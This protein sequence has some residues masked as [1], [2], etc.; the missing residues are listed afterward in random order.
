ML[1]PRIKRSFLFSTLLSLTLIVILIVGVLPV[2]ATDD[3]VNTPDELGPY[4]V[5]FFRTS[6]Y[7]ESYGTYLAKVK[8]P[9]QYDGRRACKDTSGA[10]YPALVISSGLGAGA[11]TIDWVGDHLT[12]HG[13]VTI[14]ISPPRPFDSS[15]PGQWAH[16]FIGGISQIKALNDCC[17]CPVRNMVDTE[18]L[19]IIGLS[20]GG[21]GALQA[22]GLCEE[23]DATVALAPAYSDYFSEENNEIHM[24]AVQNISV[25][26]QIQQGTNDWWVPPETAE[27]YYNLIPNSTVKELIEINGANHIGFLDGP[28]ASLVWF[29]DYIPDI[30][31]DEQRRISSKYYTSWFNYF[32]KDQSGYAPYLV[33]AEAQNDYDTGV[34]S[35]LMFKFHGS[36]R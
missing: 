19:G 26:T 23:I 17:F 36:R 9:A 29:L 15:D 33:G 7:V 2:Q 1:L 10:P 18:T 14:T 8:Y 31:N 6:F 30:D 11:W 16:G 27:E 13:Y 35:K 12:S 28:L 3:P 25:P 24:E 4:S 5:G 22:T 32:L 21:A 20:L 34:L